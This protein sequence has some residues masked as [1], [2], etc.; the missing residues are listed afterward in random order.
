M[1][2]MIISDSNFATNLDDRKSVSGYVATIGGMI[3][4][5]SSKTQHVVTL[6]STEA[7]YV[8]MSMAVQEGVF[9]F[10]QLLELGVNREPIL[11]NV[12]NLGAKFLVENDQISPRTKHIDVRYHFIKELWR[13]GHL[14]VVHIQGEQ[15]ASDILTKNPDIKSFQRHAQNL[16]SGKIIIY[17][18]E[19]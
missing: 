5:W 6:S 10:N 2:P 19:C 15:N 4:S 11:V 8:A 14:K 13:K 18:G 1:V 9:L 17:E 3:T 16:T 12:D 7:E